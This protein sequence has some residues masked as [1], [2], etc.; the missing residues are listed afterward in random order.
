MALR[1]YEKTKQKIKF[2]IFK[3]RELK[4]R[5]HIFAV[6]V[7]L[8]RHGNQVVRLREDHHRVG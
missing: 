2:I 5:D 3:E 6:R 1:G 7:R 8:R 4:Q